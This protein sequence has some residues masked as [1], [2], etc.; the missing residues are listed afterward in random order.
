MFDLYA[1]EGINQKEIEAK[2]KIFISQKPGSNGLFFL[3][4]TLLAIV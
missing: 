1:A 2:T 3:E 4:K